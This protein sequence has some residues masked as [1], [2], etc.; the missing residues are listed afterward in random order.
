MISP[1]AIVPSYANGWNSFLISTWFLLLQW[2][3]KW[4]MHYFVGILNIWSWF[5]GV[6]DHERSICTQDMYKH[7]P[8]SVNTTTSLV[9]TYGNLST[10]S[11]NCCWLTTS[12][13]KTSTSAG[14]NYMISHVATQQKSVVYFIG[15]G[16]H[17]DLINSF[18]TWRVLKV[19][20]ILR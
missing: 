5:C 1:L 8:I 4:V 14:M 19:C 2:L 17:V 9:I 7:R 10:D 15:L 6:L 20:K 12:D 18:I 3:C 11:K 16:G 13:W